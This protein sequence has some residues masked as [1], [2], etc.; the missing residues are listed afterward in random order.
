MFFV[1]YLK[2]VAQAYMSNNRG[3][4][5][6]FTPHLYLVLRLWM[7]GITYISTPTCIHCVCRDN[8][9]F[10]TFPF[11]GYLSWNDKEKDVPLITPAN[12]YDCMLSV[13]DEW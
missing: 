10:F 12:C 1:V 7:S 5:I 6:R 8:V 4:G 11:T 9:T 13:V 3:E 2:S